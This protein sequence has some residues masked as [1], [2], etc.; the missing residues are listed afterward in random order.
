MITIRTEA[1]HARALARVDTLWSAPAGSPEA[2]ELNALAAAIE[3]W[4]SA[5]LDAALP[6]ARPGPLIASKLRE[7]GWSQRELGRRLGWSTGRVSEVINGR[8]GLTLA[9][10][11]DLA[12]EL[13]ID[14]NLLVHEGKPGPSEATWV[15]LPA[16]L[17]RAAAA[18]G[19]ADP[20]AL[21]ALVVSAVRAA[22]GRCT[23]S[24]AVEG[25][26]PIGGGAG[27]REGGA[28][29]SFHDTRRAA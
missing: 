23:F 3:A 25:L 22:V 21:E 5:I 9:M 11:R 10:V 8:R 27:A 6:P 20:A 4:E 13:G 12:A 16:E 2:D 15:R 29:L 7:L 17:V 1:D 14:A 28:V 26:A 19:H 18:A 24:A